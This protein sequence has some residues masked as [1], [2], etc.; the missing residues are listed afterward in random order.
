MRRRSRSSAFPIYSALK[1]TVLPPTE[2]LSISLGNF[3]RFRPF[4]LG[5]G[6]VGVHL[7]WDSLHW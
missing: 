3:A 1:G 4:L 5:A 6:F 2:L 7:N